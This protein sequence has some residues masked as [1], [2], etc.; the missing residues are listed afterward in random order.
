VIPASFKT[1]WPLFQRAEALI[2]MPAKIL[3]AI[4]W[5]ES[6]FGDALSP[7]GP[8]GTGDEGHGRGL[9]QIDDRWHKDFCATEQW[10]DPWANI[11][12]GSRILHDALGFFAQRGFSGPMLWRCTIAAYNAGCSAVLK[13][14]QNAAPPDPDSP[15]TGRDYSAW[16]LARVPE[17]E[18]EVAHDP[19]ATASVP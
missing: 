4:C 19:V 17:I 7:K 16:V 18:R 14:V 6:L 8:G 2:G 5:R 9:M 10:K 15:T 3:A 13:A 12:M 1:Y 11:L